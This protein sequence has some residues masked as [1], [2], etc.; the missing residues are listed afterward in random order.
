MKDRPTT[1]LL[2]GVHGCFSRETRTGSLLLDGALFL[3]KEIVATANR[4]HP[5][6]EIA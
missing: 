1:S 4:P 5:F 2:A 6:A 3:R